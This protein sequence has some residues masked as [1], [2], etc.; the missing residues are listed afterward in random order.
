MIVTLSASHSQSQ[1]HRPYCVGP[2]DHLLEAELVH[3]GSTLTVAGGITVESGGNLLFGG[4]AGENIACDL[5]DRELVEGHVP[6]EGLDDP[7]SI[8]PGIR[9]EVILP[10]TVTI[11][12]AGQVQPATSPPFPIVG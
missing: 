2:V 9:S 10:I 5:L 1:P 8:A 11:R 6:V 3:V 7:V 12:V 4:G